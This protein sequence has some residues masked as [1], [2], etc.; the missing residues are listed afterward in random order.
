MKLLADFFFAAYSP[1]ELL[2]SLHDIIFNCET[3][4]QEHE[5]SGGNKMNGG[6][7]KAE[8]G[9]R[10]GSLRRHRDIYVS[11]PLLLFQL[12]LGLKLLR[13]VFFVVVLFFFFL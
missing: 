1:P 9:K 3:S 10:G 5:F 2:S 12:Y 8:S 7:Y 6:I 11:S 4:K 13:I